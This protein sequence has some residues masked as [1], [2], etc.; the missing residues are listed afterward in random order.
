MDDNYAYKR[1]SPDIEF[2]HWTFNFRIFFSLRLREIPIFMNEVDVNTRTVSDSSSFS[3]SALY[4]IKPVTLYTNSRYT[5]VKF[6][7]NEEIPVVAILLYNLCNRVVH[8]F[9]IRTIFEKLFGF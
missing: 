8:I 5:V 9:V 1:R 6:V 7:R 4:S 2:A 3:S